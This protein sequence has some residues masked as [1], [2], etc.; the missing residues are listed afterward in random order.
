MLEIFCMFMSK[1]LPHSIPLFMLQKKM[2][3]SYLVIL[4]ECIDLAASDSIELI[5]FMIFFLQKY[6][7][8]L[9]AEEYNISMCRNVTYN[10]K[11]LNAENIDTA[12]QTYH[13]VSYY[14]YST[15]YDK[16]TR[17]F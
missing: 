4:C 3:V 1:P 2:D 5:F 14:L 17:S 15:V 6:L 10:D 16:S 7:N 13:I 9:S 11:V 12:Q 8:H